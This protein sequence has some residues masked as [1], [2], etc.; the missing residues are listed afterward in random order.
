M[1]T[2]D[3]IKHDMSEL[4]EGVKAGDVDLKLASELANITG[5]FLKAAHLELARDVFLANAPKRLLAPD[6]K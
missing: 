1:K 6:D 4:Y 2:L 3:D 5:K